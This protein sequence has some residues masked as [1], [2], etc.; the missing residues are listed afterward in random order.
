MAQSFCCTTRESVRSQFEL[1]TVTVD[2]DSKWN[3]KTVKEAEQESGVEI[4]LV[5]QNGSSFKPEDGYRIALGD[6]LAVLQ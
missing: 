1:K 2:I 5:R 4:V 6:E 3:G